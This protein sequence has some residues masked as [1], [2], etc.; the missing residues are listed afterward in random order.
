MVYAPTF[1]FS[2]QLFTSSKLADDNMKKYFLFD[3]DLFM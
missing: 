2:I 1:T 3:Q